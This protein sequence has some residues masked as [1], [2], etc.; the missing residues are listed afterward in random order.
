M[1]RAA[2]Y[3]EAAEWARTHSEGPVLLT[4]GSKTLAV[5]AEI[6]G[7]ER[8]VVRVLPT[9]EA[10][11]QCQRLGL[12]AHQIV[13]M[14]G[15][16]GH[17]LNKAL[18]ERFGIRLLVSKDGGEAG[19]LPEKLSA[20]AECAVPVVLVDRPAVDYP[21]RHARMNDILQALDEG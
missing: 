4:T 3:R 19:G 11:R 8:L 2:D 15:P 7:A 16:F 20:A 12:A 9:V 5:F 17:A 1:I 21:G 6:L 10:L 18:I 14:Q 13:A